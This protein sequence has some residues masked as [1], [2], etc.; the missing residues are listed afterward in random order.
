MQGLRIEHKHRQKSETNDQKFVEKC[1]LMGPIHIFWHEQE[2]GQRLFV[3]LSSC[4]SG[5]L[6]V[7]KKWE[8]LV[9]TIFILENVV[10]PSSVPVAQNSGLYFFSDSREDYIML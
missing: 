10:K 8:I 5:I 7:V 3:E 4:C 1:S 9:Y 6:G 2:A